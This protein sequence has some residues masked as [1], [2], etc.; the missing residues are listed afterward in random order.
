[1]NGVAVHFKQE[2]QKYTNK[3]HW[4]KYDINVSRGNISEFGKAAIQV[5]LA[6]QEVELKELLSYCEKRFSVSDML[7]VREG[8]ENGNV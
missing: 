8:L 7:I 2:V 5:E 6:K 1:M 4:L 3:I